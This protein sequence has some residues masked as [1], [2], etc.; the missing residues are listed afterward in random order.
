MVSS[1]VVEIFGL[2]AELGTLAA[3]HPADVTVLHDERGRFTLHDNEGTQ[4]VA[5]R[6]L[7][8]DFCLRE[9]RRFDADASILPEVAAA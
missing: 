6:R 2:P 8:P 5:E 7:R 3:G 1:N 9:G 4:I